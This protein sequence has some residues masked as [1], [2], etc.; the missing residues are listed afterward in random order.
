MAF[1]SI[2]QYNEERYGGFFLLHNDG[3]FADV[4]FLYPSVRDVLIA[5]T[6]YIKSPDYSGY[7]HCCGKG[8]PAC[9][10]GLKVQPKLF[11]PMYNIQDDEIQ[12]WDRGV[13]FGNILSSAVFSK[14]PNPTEYVFRITRRGAAGDR[15]TVYDIVP[16]GRNTVK[17]YSQILAEKGV[18]L[19]DYY[20]KICKEFTTF[21]MQELLNASTSESSD[22]YE[23]PNYQVTPRK[24]GSEPA[25]LPDTEALPNST[26][27]EMPDFS[28]MQIGDDVDFDDSEDADNVQ[29]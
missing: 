27:Y 25:P 5:D 16:A 3:D 13:R 9:G 22:N 15:N 26:P 24:F 28:E 8:C 14:F 10:K 17:T 21:E 12:F 23:I 4:I 2:E 6:H 19:P 29:F 20:S 11:I 7:V 18:K 1:K